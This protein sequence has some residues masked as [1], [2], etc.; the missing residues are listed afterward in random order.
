[1]ISANGR[2]RCN[3]LSV[4]Y[5]YVQVRND[6]TNVYTRKQRGFRIRDGCCLYVRIFVH[7]SW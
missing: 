3:S 4:G 2:K 7:Q 6:H 1:M 5:F